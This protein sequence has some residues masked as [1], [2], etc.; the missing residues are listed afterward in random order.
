MA[1]RAF[2]LSMSRRSGSG[3]SRWEDEF[4]RRGGH[5]QI[6]QHSRRPFQR[7]FQWDMAWLQWLWWSSVCD[8]DL[9]TALT[10]SRPAMLR[11][12][13]AALDGAQDAPRAPAACLVQRIAGLE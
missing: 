4:W 12:P 6:Q 2:A 9:P 8:G 10:L 11:P 7:Q 13:A 5:L 3:Q 1:T